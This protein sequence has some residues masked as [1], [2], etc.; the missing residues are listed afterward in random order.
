[1]RKTESAS[2]SPLST[3]LP[4]GQSTFRDLCLSSGNESR[5]QAQS[6]AEESNCHV[7][8]LQRAIRKAHWIPI[9][10]RL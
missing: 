8:R 9:V 4:Y 6:S 10:M 2:T 5:T 7:C 3:D 1:M